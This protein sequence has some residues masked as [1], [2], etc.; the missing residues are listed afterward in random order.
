MRHW[1]LVD[2]L[3]LIKFNRSNYRWGSLSSNKMRWMDGRGPTR[4]Q[5]PRVRITKRKREFC[6]DNIVIYI[7]FGMHDSLNLNINLNNSNRV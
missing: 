5:E 7:L 3:R 2:G 6:A 1:L 4:R